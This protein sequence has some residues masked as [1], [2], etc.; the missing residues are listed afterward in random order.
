MSG[1]NHLLSDN[2]SVQECEALVFRGGVWSPGLFW[3]GGTMSSGAKEPIK[4]KNSI[5]NCVFSS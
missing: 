3:G 4:V 2:L 5:L 1:P